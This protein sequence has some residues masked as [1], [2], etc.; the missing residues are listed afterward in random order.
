MA[1]GGVYDSGGYH[2]G[3]LASIRKQA[4]AIGDRVKAESEARIAEQERTGLIRN[5]EN[6]EMV[7]LSSVSQETRDRWEQIEQA[8][9]V[10]PQEAMIGFLETAPHAEEVERSKELGAKASKIQ[11]KMLAGKKLSGEEKKFLREHFPD[12][13]AKAERMEQEAEQLERKL[14]GCK[15]KEE[16]QQAYMDAKMGIM[17]SASKEDGALL[18][19]IAAIEA[20]YSEYLKQGA[21]NKLDFWA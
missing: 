20:A 21:G 10:S 6:G 12:L 1:V 2:F 13:A 11:D 18:F 4:Y 5:P 3:S 9:S 16:A 7:E 14:R 15:T 8:R 17:N 19:Y